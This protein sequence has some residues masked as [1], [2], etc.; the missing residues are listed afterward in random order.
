MIDY[1]EIKESD[2]EEF[3]KLLLKLDE[4]TNF[5]MLEVG[6][7][8]L[9][10]DVQLKEINSIINSKNSTILIALD[11]ETPVGFIVA[12][13]GGYRRNSHSCY[14][15]MGILQNY[16]GKGIGKSL[17]S[18][19]FDW[20]TKTGIAR[21]ELTV[22]CHNEKA[23]GLYKKMGFEIEGIKKNS[24]FVNS[25]FVDEYYMSKVVV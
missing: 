15:A 19:I 5:M 25:R 11:N 13:G 18:E 20:G 8:N 21:Y 7:R 16:S 9:S 2:A 24:L 23:L 14:L 17:F 4:E 22:M 3:L 1:R 10:P 6:E 12:E